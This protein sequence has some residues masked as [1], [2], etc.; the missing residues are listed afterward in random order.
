[1]ENVFLKQSFTQYWD[2]QCKPDSK[3]S[4]DFTFCSQTNP[5][6]GRTQEVAIALEEFLLFPSTAIV[7]LR[8]LE[9]SNLLCVSTEV[10]YHE[11]CYQM[12]CTLI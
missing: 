11:I 1:M 3:S 2:L 5:V 12:M 8:K 7:P 4:W 10:V 9:T 6:L